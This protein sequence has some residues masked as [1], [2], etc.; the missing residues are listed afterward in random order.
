[1]Q[2]LITLQYEFILLCVFPKTPIST[3]VILDRQQV[4]RQRMES[5]T[6]NF[7]MCDLRHRETSAHATLV[8]HHQAWLYRV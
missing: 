8:H 7:V 1:M 2:V 3:P 5:K 6:V 4:G